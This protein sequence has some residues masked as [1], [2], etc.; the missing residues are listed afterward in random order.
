MSISSI[1]KKLIS[2]VIILA[3]FLS[4]FPMSG[5]KISAADSE[6][7][8]EVMGANIKYD[9]YLENGMQ[10]MRFAIKVKNAGNANMCGVVLQ[11]EDEEKV[12]VI[13][14]DKDHKEMYEINKD[15]DYVVYTVIVKNIDKDHE[16][17]KIYA[18]GIVRS[19]NSDGSDEVESIKYDS[20]STEVER[21]VT[22]IREAMAEDAATQAPANTPTAKPTA[23]PTVKPTPTAKPTVKP[24]TKPDESDLY[25]TVDLSNSNNY[26]VD[27][28]MATLGLS[29][30]NNAFN[31]SFPGICG[32]IIKAPSNDR[33]TKVEMTY[34][35]TNSLNGYVFDSRFTDGIGQ[36]AVGQHD[37]TKVTASS[38]ERTVTF[39]YTSDCIKAVKLVALDGS[40]DISIKSVKFYKYK[41]P[42][43]TEPP[44]VE[45]YTKKIMTIDVTENTDK[46]YT[47][48]GSTCNVRM[49]YFSA[50]VSGDY[51]TGSTNANDTGG[52][53][54]VVI[55]DY[56]ENY[57][58]G[59]KQYCA[60][61]IVSGRDNTGASCKFFIEDNGVE[62]PDGSLISKPIL[63]TNSW[64]LAWME[65]A[66]I[67]GVISEKAGRKVIDIMWNES[68][69]TP[70]TP[71]PVVR[72]DNSKNY[73]RELFVF[74]VSVGGS[75]AVEG[76]NANSSM[77]HFNVEAN[78]NNF[79]GNGVD[80]DWGFVDTRKQ[81]KGQV[82]S[83]SAR[84]ILEGTDVNNNPCKIYVENNGIDDNG[85]VT[86]PTIITDSP[87]YAW[88][89]TA[90]LHGTVSWG[91]KLNIH[92]WTTSN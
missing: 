70:V 49:Q 77:I 68:N 67:I 46:N 5:V 52:E 41:E 80:R 56:K 25:S 71:A 18:Y 14:T 73:N 83:L 72:P 58:N 34:T 47:V 35:S 61:Y 23:K 20:F 32:I 57:K 65:T 54:S 78:C 26:N 16:S 88:I 1:G 64:S 17:K 2:F 76:S 4:F 21:S 37:S 59:E 82:Q 63:I 10:A 43:P 51:F 55:K 36:T 3:M 87:A 38:A 33:Y 48:N 66:D 12:T 39:E 42:E 86:E 75:Y 29:Y 27:N 90:P 91:A 40:A 13:S 22:G 31:V 11:V 44:K 81:F 92:M 85:M 15:E 19:L 6:P 50:S 89:E 84:Y 9:D 24:T 60:R 30:V 74:N 69:K 8:V 28:A 79:K 7:T 45:D 53:G 62:M